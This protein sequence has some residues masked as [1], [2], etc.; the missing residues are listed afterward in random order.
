MVAGGVLECSG[1][2][3]G[4]GVPP[5]S[6][7]EGDARRSPVKEMPTIFPTSA[8]KSGETSPASSLWTRTE[9][10]GAASP[11]A[12]AGDWSVPSGHRPRDGGQFDARA[13][14]D[15]RASLQIAG[16][17]VASRHLRLLVDE[18]ER[19][20]GIDGPGRVL[21]VTDSSSGHTAVRTFPFDAP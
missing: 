18:E 13:A 21:G 19:D 14:G 10:A 11:G 4:L 5:G 16:Q 20:V 1:D 17:Q 8:I 12:A 3:K 15:G 2:T 6:T 7:Q 9:H